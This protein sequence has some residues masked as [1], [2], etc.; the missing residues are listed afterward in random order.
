MSVLTKEDKI[1]RQCCKKCEIKTMNLT[2]FFE[3]YVLKTHNIINF[4][5]PRQKYS[6]QHN[7]VTLIF[8]TKGLLKKFSAVQQAHFSSEEP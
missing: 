3:T 6:V 5:L 8:V 2:N 1:S 4:I 7:C